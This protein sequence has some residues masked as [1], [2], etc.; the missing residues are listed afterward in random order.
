MFITAKKKETL[1]INSPEI[2][3]T[4][5]GDKIY[6][7]GRKTKYSIYDNHEISIAY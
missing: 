4:N 1:L 5:R 7:N 6:N 3:S 2:I